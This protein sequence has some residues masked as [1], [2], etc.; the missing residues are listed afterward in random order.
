[1]W[2]GTCR[3]LAKVFNLNQSAEKLLNFHRHLIILFRPLLAG[4]VL[5]GLWRL[6]FFPNGINLG[7]EDETALT[8]MAIP[9][10][11]MFHS[12]LA[13]MVLSK[14]WEEF[15]TIQRCVRTL[16]KGTFE[17]CTHDR[18][19]GTIHLLLGAMSVIIIGG[20]MLV[21]YKNPWAG[22][23]AVGA[24]SFFLVLYWEVATTLDNPAK[25][26]WFIGKIPVDW[27]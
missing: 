3:Y 18:I 2:V 23:G 8:N 19:P 21:E 22:M 11:A 14:V 6:F 12:I 7:K 13:A 16:D 17:E 15:K 5:S 24:V 4:M 1:V 26:P 20:T 27:L 25:A 10:C 9:I